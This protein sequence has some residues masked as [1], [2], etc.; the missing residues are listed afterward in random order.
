[1]LFPF[2]YS[3][4][5]VENYSWYHL[6]FLKPSV[7]KK[8]RNL[9]LRSYKTKLIEENKTKEDFSPETQDIARF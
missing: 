6:Y 9:V 1:M 8:N 4:L 7:E 3:T 2:E 5:E